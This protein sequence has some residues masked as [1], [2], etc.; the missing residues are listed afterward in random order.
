MNTTPLHAGI[1][2]AA[3]RVKNL[4][5]SL[6]FWK[7]VLGFSSY[8]EFESDWAMVSRGETSL[9][10][11]SSQ[12]ESGIQESHRTGETGIHHLGITVNEKDQV[13]RW[14]RALVQARE[15]WIS[16]EIHA[17]KLHRDQSYGFYFRDPD[18]NAF[19][20][21]W[22]PVIHCALKDLP[23]VVLLGHGSRDP[24]WPVPILKLKSLLESDH[25]AL[26]V[27][28]AWME[29]AEPT[30]EQA[31]ETLKAR[32]A[33]TQVVIHPVF[34]SAGGHVSHDIPALVSAA[35]AAHPDLTL[36]LKGPLGELEAVLH[37]MKTE[38]LTQA[39][40]SPQTR[41]LNKG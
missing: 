41:A 8:R 36:E 38:I 6:R 16:L 33:P 3:I 26:F 18:G 17:P 37:A 4:S 14:H 21:I 19:E 35:R 30:L 40:E 2:H 9:S 27:E 15:A 29:F 20:V 28:V 5:H 13:D 31:I 39:S 7:E 24:R 34:I 22:I 1:R 25:P 23:A 11:I 12:Y 10:L 32:K